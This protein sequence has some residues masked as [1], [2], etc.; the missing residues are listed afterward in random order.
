MARLRSFEKGT[1]NVKAHPT[2]VDC[3]HQV[4]TAADGTR[5]LHLTTFGSDSRRSGPKSSQSLQIDEST[6]RELM[7]VIR[8]T[9]PKIE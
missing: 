4:I 7:A 5:L 3:F 2:E 8:A 6:A 9:F 1:Q